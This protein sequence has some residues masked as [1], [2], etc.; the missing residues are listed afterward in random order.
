MGASGA[1]TAASVLGAEDL[2]G[3]SEELMKYAITAITSSPASIA[4][5]FGSAP[6]FS[7]G[8][9]ASFFIV[10]ACPPG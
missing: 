1:G 4:I 8:F 6:S 3:L 7:E 2:G 9:K 5:F 10:P